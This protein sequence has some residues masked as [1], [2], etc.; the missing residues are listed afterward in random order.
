MPPRRCRNGPPNAGI[1]ALAAGDCPG[2]TPTAVARSSLRREPN[3]KETFANDLF[4]IPARFCHAP[5]PTLLGC[6][7]SGSDWDNFDSFSLR[8]APNNPAQRPPA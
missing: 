4:E 5:T 6:V 7:G 1:T 2:G 3:A 8:S